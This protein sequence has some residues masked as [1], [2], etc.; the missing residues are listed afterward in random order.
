VSLS[1]LDQTIELDRGEARPLWWATAFVW[2]RTMDALGDAPT[3][4]LTAGQVG[5][6]RRKPRRFRLSVAELAVLQTYVVPTAHAGSRVVLGK[7]QHKSLNL[8]QYLRFD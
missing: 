5:L 6:P 3:G 1:H 7:V 8:A 2:K 4:Q